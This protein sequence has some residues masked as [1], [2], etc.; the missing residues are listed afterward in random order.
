[1]FYGLALLA[2]LNRY[3]NAHPDNANQLNKEKRKANRCGPVRVLKP[4][5]DTGLGETGNQKDQGKIIKQ[6]ALYTRG[7]DRQNDSAID[8]QVLDAVCVCP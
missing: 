4:D 1:M 8:R 3:I 2:G 7:H 5:M 6:R